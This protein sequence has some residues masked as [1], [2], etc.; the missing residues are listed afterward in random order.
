[1]L[2]LRN[3]PSQSTVLAISHTHTHTHTRAHAHTTH[4]H[5]LRSVIPVVY[6]RTTVINDQGIAVKKH[7]CICM[8]ND[9]TTTCFGHLLTGHHQV[10][11]QCQMNY[12]HTKNL[13]IS[14]S[15][16]TEKRGGDEISFTKNEACV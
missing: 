1:M 2:H 11:I 8:Y 10:G 12:I 6:I 5:V 15:V 4:T 9:L 13:V 16:S 14:V 7:N 3:V